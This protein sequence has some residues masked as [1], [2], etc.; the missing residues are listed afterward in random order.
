MGPKNAAETFKAKN[1]RAN[2]YRV[3]LYGSL[4][5]TGKGHLTDKALISALSATKTEIIW[6]KEQCLPKHPNG[7]I[8]EALDK[9]GNVKDTW[10]V[11]SIGGGDLWDGESV[12]KTDSLYP[13]T[14]MRDILCH[15]EKEN[16]TLW[17]F[18][19]QVEGPKIW[20]YLEL[21]QDKMMKALLRGI[22]KKGKLPGPLNLKRKAHLYYEKAE[23]PQETLKKRNRIFAYA[24]AVAEENASGGEIVTAPT[25]GSCG[26]VPSVLRVMMHN[27]KTPKTQILKALATAGLLGNLAKENASISGAAVGCQGEI[28]VA[29]AMAS[30]AIAQLLGANNKQIEYAAEMG[31]EH[32]LG[33]TC[34]PIAGLVQIP[35]I[36]RNAMAASRAVDCAIYALA[37][38]GNHFV[39]Y[40]D[41][42]D[43]MMATGQDLSSKYRETA[44]GG[45]AKRFEHALFEPETNP[46]C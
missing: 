7:M 23:H 5:T 14:K 3:S 26:V 36:E 15:C 18:V 8:F 13:F 6:H 20:N 31:L 29:C 19:E 28:G 41:V 38:D 4:A 21:V 40:D 11:Y 9:N 22:L 46:K 42:L 1:P 45:L 44:L 17:Q 34:D 12:D 16:I 32:H 2:T 10:T 24:L 25:C 39:S 43:T 33:L 35:C 30:G 37:S 27:Y